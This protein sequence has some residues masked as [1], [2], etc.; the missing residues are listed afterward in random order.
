MGKKKGALPEAPKEAPATEQFDM[1]FHVQLAHGSPTR[2]VRDFTNVKQLHES[3]AKAF[4][5]PTT[6]V[7]LLRP[8]LTSLALQAA[9]LIGAQSLPLSCWSTVSSRPLKTDPASAKCKRHSISSWALHSAS[10]KLAI[11]PAVSLQGYHGN[12]T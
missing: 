10:C 1:V 2:L 12:Q 9:L 7:R 5:I 4:G 8:A 3:I 6:D 11:S